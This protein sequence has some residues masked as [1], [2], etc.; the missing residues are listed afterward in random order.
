LPATPLDIELPLPQA[1]ADPGTGV[2]GITRR[3]GDDVAFADL[4]EKD[5]LHPWRAA[6]GAG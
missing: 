1:K 6:R 3:L 2:T 4:L 5:V